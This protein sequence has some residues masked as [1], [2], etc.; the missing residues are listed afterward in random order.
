MIRIGVISEP[1]PTPVSPTIS[2]SPR[3]VSVN[4]QLTGSRGREHHAGT[5]RLVRR[6]VDEDE[7]A[8]GAIHGIRI[9][10]ERLREAQAHD[11]DVVQ[12]EPLGSRYVLDRV[13]V[14][15]GYELVGDRAHRAGR[16]LHGEPRARLER[17]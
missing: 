3:P 4:C 15:T 7:G 8:R 13:D 6:L 11:A 10:T 17:A 16:L 2:P 5:H 9:D 1:P 12:L 14:D